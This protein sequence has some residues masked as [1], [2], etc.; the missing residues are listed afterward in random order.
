M[1][2]LEVVTK[3]S[4]KEFID[5]P[6]SLY[7]DD[8]FW[9]CPLDSATES[10]FDPA[11][12]HA[13]KHGE[14]S[15]WILTD[16]GKTIGRIAAFI[17][18]VRSSANNQPTGG[19][20]FFEVIE[21][22]EAAFLLFDTAKSWLKDRGM[23]AMD[24]P[25][26]FGENDTN[27][28]LLAEGFIQQGFGMPYHKRYYRAFFEEYGFRTYF[29]QYSYHRM[30]R[31]VNNEIVQFPERIMKIAAWLSKRPGY[32][33]QHFEARKKEKYV[34][35]IVEIYNSAWSVFKEDFTPLETAFLYESFEKAREILD[36]ELI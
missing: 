30:I 20:G 7:R 33:F 10:V 36:E 25:F 26:N 32:T 4:R 13:F 9:V 27:W 23:E 11:I 15:R 18:T 3:H 21:S 14:A 5:L 35:D 1:Q 17:D 29:E 34:R 12:N 28:G 31:G 24:G 2:I 6:K 22:R 19:I 16:D 8:P